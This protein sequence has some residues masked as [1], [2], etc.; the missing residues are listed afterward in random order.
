MSEDIIVHPFGEVESD[1]VE[2]VD[3]A[4]ARRFRMRVRPGEQLSIPA[5]SYSRERGQYLSTE[6]LN[7]LA[8]QVHDH[9]RARL[10]ITNVDLFVGELNFVFGE[11]S[12]TLGAAVFST[13]R[14]DP[15][16]YKETENQTL[17]IRRATTEAVHELGHVFGLG[18]CKQSSCVMWFSN[19]SP[20][21]IAREADFVC[22]VPSCL[23]LLCAPAVDDVHWASLPSTTSRKGREWLR[24]SVI[25]PSSWRASMLHGSCVNCYDCAI[26]SGHIGLPDCLSV[27]RDTASSSRR[28]TKH[29]S[30]WGC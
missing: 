22:D 19:S 24:A 10:G 1:L 21:Q 4:V 25:D 6:L 11:A 18:H 16:A 15:R 29:T 27:R 20:K 26:P 2:A 13:A 7:V 30:I 12:T 14:L 23:G 9:A 17:F 28:I 5:R 3:L 8:T